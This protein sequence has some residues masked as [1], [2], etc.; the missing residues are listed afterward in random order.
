MPLHQPAPTR[1]PL[2]PRRRWLL[3]ALG[4]SVGAL[5]A[6]AAP[7]A[8]TTDAAGRG[9]TIS[10]TQLGLMVGKLFPLRRQVQGLLEMNLHSPQLRLMPAQNRLGTRLGVSVTEPFLG[11][12]HEGQVEL[13]Y[14]LRFEPSDRSIRMTDVR[15]GQVQFA[16][17]PAGLREA[18][19]QAAPRVL[20]PLLSDYVLHTVTPQQMA[21]VNALGWAVRGLRITEGG[22]RVEL[23]AP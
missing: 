6:C 21:L 10:E 14:G 2:S 3:A 9:Y 13:D 17:L 22:L 4:T 7:A 5:M 8:T 20:E 1:L 18:L 11:S 19:G 15:V 16:R 12:T 23:Q